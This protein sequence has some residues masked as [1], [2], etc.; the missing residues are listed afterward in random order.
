MKSFKDKKK[1]KTGYKRTV[2]NLNKE[3]K[4][5]RKIFLRKTADTF[6]GPECQCHLKHEACPPCSM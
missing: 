4:E 1:R 5:A 6:P 2:R 3:E